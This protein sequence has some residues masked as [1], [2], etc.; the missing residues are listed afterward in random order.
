MRSAEFA[1]ATAGQRSARRLGSLHSSTEA[2][3]PTVIS[4]RSLG[5]GPLYRSAVLMRR[6]SACAMAGKLLRMRGIILA[7]GIGSRPSRWSLA[8]NWYR[9]STSR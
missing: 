5:T 7:G 1:A 9:C 2:N 8:S 3:F 6:L 4:V